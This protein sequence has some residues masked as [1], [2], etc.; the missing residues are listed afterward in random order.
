[1]FARWFH[2]RVRAA[3]KA[4][5][6]GRLD[7]ALAIARELQPTDD[8]DYQKLCDALAAP[9]EARARLHRQAGRYREAL[10][11][12][13]HLAA[14]NREGPDAQELRRQVIN[15]L[16]A[17]AAQTAE[18]RAAWRRAAAQVRAGHLETG[19][20][21]LERIENTRLR[22]QLG[23]EL[24][25]RAGRLG[26]L[27]QQADEALQRGDVL[28]AVRHWDE[29]GR[30]GQT[31]ERERFL[32][33][34]ADA[35]RELVDRWYADGRIE[36]LMTARPAV[37]ALMTCDPA[38]S[39]CDLVIELCGRA[40]G[41]LAAADYSGLRH[42]L[43]R[44]RA[45]R[46]DVSWVRAALD[47]LARI[48]EGQE[49]LLA[50]PLGLYA[51][52]APRA[53]TA[54]AA[55]AARV[56]EVPAVRVSAEADAVR[57]DTPLI[58]LV[59]SGGSSMLLAREQVRIGRAGSSAMV[60]VALPADLDSHH[61]DLIRRGSDYFVIAH[62]P[63]EVNQRPVRQCLL[64]HGDVITLGRVR[65]T[66]QKPSSRSQTAVLQLPH[67]CRLAEDVSSVILFCDTCLVG[68]TLTCHIRTRESEGQ[69]VLFD[70]SGV[71][72]ARRMEERPTAA[73]LAPAEPVVVGR[74][75]ELAGLRFT[76][77]PYA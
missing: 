19:R 57:L 24:E 30:E 48:E 5:R 20:A 41:Q 63:V 4:L 61:A 18:E 29:A 39:D 17:D 69:L 74:T 54:E 1:M 65:L 32:P 16:Q 7:D 76:V 15:E 28:A 21:E 12:L 8:T 53:A 46:G 27:L 31:P 56:R 59:D 67:R 77:K 36:A 11:D 38:L 73:G 68:P 6:Q 72:Y 70:R 50:S 23:A 9:L 49:Q 34:L 37:A 25:R 51:S 45:A 44:L 26:R 66:F 40:A 13:N 42:T 60:D 55:G 62:G 22:E 10:A 43:L 35:C 52:M 75:M 2:V 71:L 47:A 64:R 33:E 58:V 3:V 14:L